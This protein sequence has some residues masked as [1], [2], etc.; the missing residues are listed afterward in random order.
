[1]E[2]DVFKSWFSSVCEFFFLLGIAYQFEI[3]ISSVYSYSLIIGYYHKI[4]S[5]YL[6]LFYSTLLYWIKSHHYYNYSRKSAVSVIITVETSQKLLPQE[7]YRERS[8]CIHLLL[9]S[10]NVTREPKQLGTIT[11][12]C[13]ITTSATRLRMQVQ[14]TISSEGPQDVRV[15][16]EVGAGRVLFMRL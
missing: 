1:M 3:E 6:T 7:P 14:H 16:A 8:R 10:W 4:L 13:N 5:L 12:L 15:M 11:S 9:L 2:N